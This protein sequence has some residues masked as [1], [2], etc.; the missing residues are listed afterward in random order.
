[1][2]IPSPATGRRART[3]SAGSTLPARRR[4]H[5]DLG[6]RS[7]QPGRPRDIVGL[8]AHAIFAQ[9]AFCT[10]R[11]SGV[12]VHAGAPVIEPGM[13]GAGFQGARRRRRQ[14]ARR[15]RPRRRQGRRERAA[16]GRLGAQIRHPEHHPHRR[17]FDPRLR[18]HRRRRRAGGRR[19]RRRPHQR[20]P[21]RAARQPDP[22]HL[23][24]LQARARDRAQR[25]RARRPVHAA[26]RA[27][28][29]TSSIA[30]SSAPTAPPARACSRSASCAWS[31][32]CASL[33]T[34][35]AEIAFCFA[36]GNTARMRGS[37]A[38]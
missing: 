36:T 37:T 20:R 13:V 4:H 12:K 16:D 8:K 6:R 24:G 3:S 34:S 14:A 23:R 1:M 10:F 33:A 32:C 2:S 30:S 21:H 18:P 15:G 26:H 7:A 27:R 5:D 9:R 19:R 11:A 29:G 22:L 17:P 25:Q 31:R 38:A 35:P 28:D